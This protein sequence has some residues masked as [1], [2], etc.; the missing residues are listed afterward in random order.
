MSKENTRPASRSTHSTIGEKQV[1]AVALLTIPKSM[2]AKLQWGCIIN[3]CTLET[4][5]WRKNASE[6]MTVELEHG[7]V[8]EASARKI[9]G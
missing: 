7:G 2:E 4:R 3:A 5:T 9:R 1:I 6:F 8:K